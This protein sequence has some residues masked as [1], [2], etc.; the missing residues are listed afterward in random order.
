MLHYDIIVIG[1]GLIGSAAAKY[2]SESNKTVAIIGPDE[3]AENDKPIVYASHYDQARVQRIIGKDEVWTRLNADSAKQYASMQ[4]KTGIQFHDPVG[5]LYVNPKGKDSYLSNA[6]SQAKKFDLK[7]KFYQNADEIKND[8]N[9]YHFPDESQGIF[10]ADPS[11]L[12][13][14]RLLL[15]AQLKIF[16]QYNGSIIRETV[17]SLE[18]TT[19][20]FKVNTFE[21]NQFIADN[22]LVTTGSFLNYLDILPKKL[23]LKTKGE[24]IILIKV[25]ETEAKRLSRLPSLLYEIDNEEIEGVY[26]I[27]PVLYPDG[28]YY[29]KMGCN[30][31]E[32]I[33]FDTLEEAQNWFRIIDNSRFAVRM[34]RAV[35]EIIPDLKVESYYTH[36]C[37]ISRTSHGRPYIGE[38][39]EEGLF[40]AG[41]C[42]GYSAMCSDAIGGAA[43]DF[44]VK[45]EINKSYLKNSFEII[46]R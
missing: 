7:Y 22:V 28:N 24:V 13:N 32:D 42:N 20:H 19:E 34:K 39:E 38:T 9:D 2:L 46:Y 18:K 26:L 30:L 1:K 37:I 36:N 15:K 45:K 11:G 10:E 17:S 25:N 12:I 21:G 6:D 43:S 5:C 31:P 33:Y 35:L 29:L 44:I 23:D 4:E 41:G 27:K 40:L 14:P 3:P 8:F 16:E